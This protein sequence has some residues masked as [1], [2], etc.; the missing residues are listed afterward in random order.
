MGEVVEL[1]EKSRIGPFLHSPVS[2]RKA[3]GWK[4]CDNK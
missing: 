3:S 4:P 1:E 2:I